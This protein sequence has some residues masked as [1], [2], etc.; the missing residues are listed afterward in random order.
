MKLIIDIPED[1]Y[2]VF[3]KQHVSNSSPRDR[4]FNAV[5]NGTPIPDNATNGDVIKAMFDEVEYELI[6]DKILDSSWWNIPYQKGGA[7]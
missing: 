3:R 5:K 7:E 2:D 1:D 4:L 6:R